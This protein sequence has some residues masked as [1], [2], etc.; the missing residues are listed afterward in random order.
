MF[1]EIFLFLVAGFLGM[2]GFFLIAMLWFLLKEKS[3]KVFGL[4]LFFIL[5]GLFLLLAMIEVKYTW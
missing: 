1:V 4:V 2:L 3:Y 5:L